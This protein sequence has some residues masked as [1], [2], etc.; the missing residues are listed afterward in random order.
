MV[1]MIAAG[2]GS[3]PAAGSVCRMARPEPSGLRYRRLPVEDVVA[4]VSPSQPRRGPVR[5]VRWTSHIAFAADAL[6]NHPQ[7]ATRIVDG[8]ERALDAVA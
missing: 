2:W 1:D 4:R 8:E 7:W 6:R 3:V 5:R